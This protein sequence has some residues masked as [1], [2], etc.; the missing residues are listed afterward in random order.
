[1]TVTTETRAACRAARTALSGYVSA[2]YPA[3]RV[4][5]ICRL[6]TGS[7]SGPGRIVAAGTAPASSRTSSLRGVHLRAP[8]AMRLANL[9]SRIPRSIPVTGAS[10]TRRSARVRTLFA[11]PANHDVAMGRHVAGVAPMNFAARRTF[12]RNEF[13]LSTE[14]HETVD[15]ADGPDFKEPPGIRAGEVQYFHFRSPHG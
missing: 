5:A 15:A 9:S 6:K 2:R 3:R 10:W 8:S 11:A 7:A 14:I 1:M 4:A 12:D 13:Q